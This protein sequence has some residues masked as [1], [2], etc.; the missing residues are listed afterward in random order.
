MH[1]AYSN[2]NTAARAH[3]GLAHLVVE[4]CIAGAPCGGRVGVRKGRLDSVQLQFGSRF[5]DRGDRAVLRARA[6]IADV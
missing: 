3:D 6:G 2:A 1:D 5:A 4:A